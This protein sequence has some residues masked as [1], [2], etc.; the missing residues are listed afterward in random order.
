[1]C[2]NNSPGMRH[3]DRRQLTFFPKSSKLKS[4]AYEMFT[5]GDAHV[6]QIAKIQKE[7]GD[8]WKGRKD[9]EQFYPPL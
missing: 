3:P 7:W 2:R 4:C 6:L 1:M 8:Y 5:C 9:Q